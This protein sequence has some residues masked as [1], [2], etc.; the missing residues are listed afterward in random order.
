MTNEQYNRDLTLRHDA[1]VAA[2]GSIE[3][4]HSFPTVA[5]VMSDGTEYYFQDSEACELLE[6]VPDYVNEEVYLLA[7]A[8]GW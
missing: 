3:I 5:I 1:E 6:T 2:G 8:Q 4:S 7:M